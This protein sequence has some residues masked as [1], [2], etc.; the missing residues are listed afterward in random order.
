MEIASLTGS[1]GAVID[2]VRLGDE[3]GSDPRWSSSDLDRL[4]DTLDERHLLTFSGPVLS[5]EA[6][7]GFTTRFGAL[8]PERRLWG[9]VSNSRPDGVVREGRLEFHSDFAFTAHPIEAICLHALEMPDDGSP[10]IYADAV[11]AVDRL[12][13]PLRARLEEMEVLNCFDLLQEGDHRMRVAEIDPRSPRCTHPIIGVHPRTGER[14]V[15]AN[16]L[17]SDSIVGIPPGESEQLLGELFEVLYDPD[18]LYEHRWSVGDVVLWDNIALHHGRAHV[19]SD[20]PRTLQRVTIGSHTP[21]ELI[22]NL[23]ELLAEKHA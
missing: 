9:Y 17:H 10:T 13:S 15:M 2:D 21:G 8:V 6:Q 19:P 22:P 11:A 5:G 20:A 3:T 23:S 18:H 14:V 7:V 12:P 16:A 4:R 1:I